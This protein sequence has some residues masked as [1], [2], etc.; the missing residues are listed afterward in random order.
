MRNL[1]APRA[2]H[3]AHRSFNA[4]RIRHRQSCAQPSHACVAPQHFLKLPKLSSTLHRR[5]SP[6][7]GPMCD[8]SPMDMPDF[9]DDALARG[10]SAAAGPGDEPLSGVASPAAEPS[11]TTY[12]NPKQFERIL[13]RRGAGAV[14]KG[15]VDG[16]GGAAAYPRPRNAHAASPRSASTECPRGVAASPPPWN[17][18]AA[19]RRH[20]L[21]E[22]SARR[23]GGGVRARSD[24]ARCRATMLPRRR[25][26]D[27][28][29]P[30]TQAAARAPSSR[31]FEKRR[32][33]KNGTCTSRGTSTRAG[34]SAAPAAVF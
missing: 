28:R 3:I 10:A 5:R 30:T 13:K 27:D 15:S 17:V 33:T 29:P 19:S 2:A 6:R 32:R 21:R 9:V 4:P 24:V 25:G 7:S 23:R 20:R 26:V 31:A 1:C 14:R 16:R 8:T 22:M 12:V 11:P 18:R 34:G